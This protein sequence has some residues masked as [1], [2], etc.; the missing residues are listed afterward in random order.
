MMPKKKELTILE[1]L[2][3]LRKHAIRIIGILLAGSCILMLFSRGIYQWLQ[4]PLLAQLPS[5]SHFVSLSLMEGWVVY[6]KV[7]LVAATFI[8]SPLW[9]YQVWAFLAPGLLSRE[10]S[11]AIWAA[12]SSSFCFIVGG[13]FGYYVIMPY[14]FRYLVSLLDSTGIALMPQMNLYLSFVLRLI[15]AFGLVFELPVIIVVLTRWDLVDVA[16]LK[17]YRRHMIVVAFI[18]GAILTPPDV[19]TQICM[20]VP[21]IALYEVGILVATLFERKQ[22]K[23]SAQT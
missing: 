1:H 12:V 15:L 10:R 22:A 2:G 13:L 14:G 17:K 5:G 11:V 16:T 7:A 20:A 19:V 23:A 6:F 9:L 4:S 8:T 18:V 21:F 3:E